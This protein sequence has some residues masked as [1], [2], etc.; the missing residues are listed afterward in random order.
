MVVVSS[1]PSPAVALAQPGTRLGTSSPTQPAQA[2]Q[3]RPPLQTPSF[4]GFQ[5]VRFGHQG[6]RNAVMASTTS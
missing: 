2:A 4:P 1:L 5:S 3:T 6:S